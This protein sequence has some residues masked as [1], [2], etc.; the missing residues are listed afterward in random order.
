MEL[1]RQVHKLPQQWWRP[2]PSSHVPTKLP[3]QEPVGP[4]G[5]QCQTRALTPSQHHLGCLPFYVTGH[6]GLFLRDGSSPQ[7]WEKRQGPR[8]GH[9]LINETQ[10]QLAVSQNKVPLSKCDGLISCI[11]REPGSSSSS[12][13]KGRRGRG[14][15]T[16]K[17]SVG[18]R[19]GKAIHEGEKGG[20]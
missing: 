18:G 3:L 10:L 2:P 17:V 12:S 1:S 16:W 13:R 14:R 5:R 20:V 19:L 7:E 15:R 4:T 6:H 8:P 11:K 9:L